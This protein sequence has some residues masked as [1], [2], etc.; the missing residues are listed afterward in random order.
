MD[1]FILFYAPFVMVFLAI[2]FAFFI[3]PK[4]RLMTKNESGKSR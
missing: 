2:W 4:D 3:A 1:N